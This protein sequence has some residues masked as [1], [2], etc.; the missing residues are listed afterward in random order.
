MCEIDDWVICTFLIICSVSDIRTR[1]IST[2]F[3]VGMSVV[4]VLFCLVSKDRSIVDMAG[5]IG[6]GAGFWLLSKYTKEAVGYGD[7]WI[8]LLLGGYM[9]GRRTVEL[10]MIAFFLAGI[11]A[12]VGIQFRKWNRKSTIPFVPFLTAAYVGVIFV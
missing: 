5:G 2:V 4:T 12:L 9:G 6:I 1:K 8:I 3:L 7:S 10:L 11:S